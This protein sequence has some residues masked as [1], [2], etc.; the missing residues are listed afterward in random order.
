MNINEIFHMHMLADVY[1]LLFLFDLIMTVWYIVL[2]I[3][4]VGVYHS[5]WCSFSLY[6]YILFCKRKEAPYAQTPNQE[7]SKH[8]ILCTQTLTHWLLSRLHKCKRLYDL[9][10]TRQILLFIN[11]YLSNNETKYIAV[12]SVITTYMIAAGRLFYV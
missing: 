9:L 1:V 3:I 12:W 4:W 11:F 8:S 7:S 2:A 6:I 10:V 5:K